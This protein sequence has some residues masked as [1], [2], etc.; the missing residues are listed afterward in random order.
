MSF[1][2][3]SAVGIALGDGTLKAVMLS[4]GKGSLRLDRSWRVPYDTAAD[5]EKAALD[6]VAALLRDAHL[7][8]ST[9]V[10]LSA[11]VRGLISRTYLVPAMETTRIAEMVRYEVL[12]ET[13][14]PA[15]DLVICHHLRHG[16]TEQQVVAYALRRRDVDAFRG[17]LVARGIEVDEVETPG[18]ALASFVEHQM[19]H[20]VERLVLGVG[21]LATELVV[22][23][24][25]GLWM[26]RLPIGLAHEAAPE[27]AR[28]L[29]QETRSALAHFLPKDRVFKPQDLVL[30]E[31]GAMDGALT[32]ALRKEFGC[33]V[34]RAQTLRGITTAWRARHEGGPP[35]QV[36]TMGTAIGLALCG[37]GA[38]RWRCPVFEGNPHR[39]ALRLVPAAAASV[40]LSA[41]ALGLISVLADQRADELEATLPASLHGELAERAGKR[42]AILAE[43]AGLVA[44][45]DALLALASRRDAVFQPRRALAA[46]SALGNERGADVLHVD[47]VWVAGPEPGRPGGMTITLDAARRFDA[48]LGDRLQRAM[49]AEFTDVRVSGPQPAPA[50]GLSRWT[51]EVPLP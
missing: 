15:E 29:Q 51:V 13:A 44:G 20:A 21:R 16:A 18:L 11:P 38:G 40:L 50:E 25:E 24:P 47:N 12:S 2:R 9:Q 19:P 6:A 30:S 33:P 17:E 42:E 1:F 45:G 32:G 4:G 26:R 46:L 28:R 43:R 31:E 5:P 34:S 14:L 7:G 23:T 49:K 10:V 37:L 41:G 8:A 27:L 39:Q 22:L 35:E 36:L 48:D 3:R